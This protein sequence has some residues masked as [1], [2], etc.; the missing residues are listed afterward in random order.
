MQIQTQMF[1][2]IFTQTNQGTIVCDTL[3]STQDTVTED[4]V[5]QGTQSPQS[6]SRHT[7]CLLVTQLLLL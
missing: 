7:E 3:R 4:E 1:E 2:P 5:A 6:C